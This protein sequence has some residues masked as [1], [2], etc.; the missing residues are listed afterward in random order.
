MLLLAS[1]K[2]T[3]EYIKLFQRIDYGYNGYDT[4]LSFFFILSVF[5]V[6]FVLYGVIDDRFTNVFIEFSAHPMGVFITL[7][8]IFSQNYER[9]F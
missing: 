1:K 8:P 6:I 2:D 9:E 3:V 4:G 7:E 5:G